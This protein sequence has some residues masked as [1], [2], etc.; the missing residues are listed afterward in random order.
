MCMRAA[1]HIRVD[2]AH[3]SACVYLDARPCMR[4]KHEFHRPRPPSGA[5]RSDPA[6]RVLSGLPPR[7]VCVL[8]SVWASASHRQR[9]LLD[10]YRN[11]FFFLMLTLPLC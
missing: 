3:T 5:S 4:H 11:T 9:F 2:C 7:H 10:F 8:S 6:P 1:V